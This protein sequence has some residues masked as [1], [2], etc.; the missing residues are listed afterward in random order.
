M[1]TREAT[2][3]DGETLLAQMPA[4]RRA[5]LSVQGFIDHL[6]SSRLTWAGVDADGVVDIGGVMDSGV[7]GIGYAWQVIDPAGVRRNK[8]AYLRQSRQLLDLAHRLYPH[9]SVVIEPDNT[10]AQR[11][12]RRMGWR[13]VGATVLPSGMR[14][15]VFERAA[16]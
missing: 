8:R 13:F 12:A 3:A 15:V 4:E 1:I 9:L 10:V 2:I 11:H 7:A 14:A 16:R 5:A 6:A